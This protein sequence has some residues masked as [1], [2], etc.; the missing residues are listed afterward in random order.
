MKAEDIQTNRLLLRKATLPILRALFDL[1]DHVQQQDFLGVSTNE[2]L[3]QEHTA[4]LVNFSANNRTFLYFILLDKKTK[5]NIG[6]CGYH[7]IQE[8]HNRAEIGYGITVESYKQKGLMTEALNVIIHFGFEHMK[9][10]RIEAFVAPNNIPSLALMRRFNF[11]QEGLL[12]Q[13]YVSGGK[14]EN[15][16][17]FS[18]L[19]HEYQPLKDN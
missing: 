16:I 5:K 6:W 14:I 8:K 9:L 7:T 10:N 17:V 2:Q 15:S 19:Q 12:R 1:D 13:H 3:T 11:V 4:F 18:I